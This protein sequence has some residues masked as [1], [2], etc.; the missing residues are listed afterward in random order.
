MKLPQHT[1]DPILEKLYKR[2]M[3]FKRQSILFRLGCKCWNNDIDTLTRK[4]E[5]LFN[6]YENIKEIH[7]DIDKMYDLLLIHKDF[8][9]DLFFKFQLPK[10]VIKNIY[11]KNIILFYS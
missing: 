9:S 6:D 7:E 10:N 1:I 3:D 8:D 11:N 2:K 5:S 4:F